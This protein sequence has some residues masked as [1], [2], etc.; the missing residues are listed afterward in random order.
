MT[1]GEKLKEVFPNTI[2]IKEMSPEGKMI[3]LVCSDEWWNKE[4]NE[5][6][7]KAFPNPELRKLYEEK[8]IPIGNEN[9]RRRREQNGDNL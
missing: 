4:Y 9:L 1:N 5:N 6:S 7:S 8:Y 3:G 2:F